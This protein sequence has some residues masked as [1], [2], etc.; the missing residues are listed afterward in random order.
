MMPLKRFLSRQF[1]FTRLVSNRRDIFAHINAD[2][3]AAGGIP[4]EGGLEEQKND[5][6][7]DIVDVPPPVQPVIPVVVVEPVLEEEKDKEKEKEKEKDKEKEKE[8]TNTVEP[9]INTSPA[10]PVHEQQDP[11]VPMDEHRTA[12]RRDFFEWK[13]KI[14]WR[15]AVVYQASFK[16]FRATT[17]RDAIVSEFETFV[18]QHSH[19]I[20]YLA[21]TPTGRA[22]LINC[23]NALSTMDCIATHRHAW[24]D[25]ETRMTA[26]FES[27]VTAIFNHCAPDTHNDLFNGLAEQCRVF[28]HYDMS[29]PAMTV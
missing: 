25:P 11:V 2:P 26:T 23:I 27:C 29:S 22:V 16:F 21:T 18:K 15:E 8:D 13:F 7:D 3:S 28:E 9:I 4:E 20:H 17:N 14:S 12:F 6:V 19:Q 10:Q 1:K 24:R 5:A